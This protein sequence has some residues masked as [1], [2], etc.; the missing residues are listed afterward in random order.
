MAIVFF[1]MVIAIFAS[2]RF[3][4]AMDLASSGM[5]H[6]VVPFRDGSARVS[7]DTRGCFG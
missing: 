5:P 1:A 6:C 4:P 7:N 3:N 2:L